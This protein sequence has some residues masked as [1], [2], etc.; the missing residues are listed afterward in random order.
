V[1]EWFDIIKKV[2]HTSEIKDGLGATAHVVA[3]AGGIKA[4][5]DTEV[6]EW[7]ENEKI[8]WHSTGGQVKMTSSMTFTPIKDGTKLTFEMDYNMPYSILGKIIEK[9]WVGNDIDKS[10]ERGMKKTKETFEK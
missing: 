1:P 7:K 4:E 3:K 2:E 9:L 10:N 5:W 8:A 6:A